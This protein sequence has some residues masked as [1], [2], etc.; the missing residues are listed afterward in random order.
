MSSYALWSRLPHTSIPQPSI[1]RLPS[2]AFLFHASTSSHRPLIHPHLHTSITHIHTTPPTRPPTHARTPHMYTPPMHAL[3]ARPPFFHF[4]D[5][6][7]FVSLI[8]SFAWPFCTRFFCLHPSYAP[9]LQLTPILHPH[10]ILRPSYRPCTPLTPPYI[11]ITHLTPP[12]S[13]PHILPR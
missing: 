1:I 3:F 4:I 12:R 8:C 6:H 10:P 7:L 5:V 11:H 2:S 9:H 13:L